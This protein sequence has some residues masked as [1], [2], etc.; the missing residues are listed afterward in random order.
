M[1][2]LKLSKR[3]VV[4]IVIVVIG[5]FISPQITVKSNVVQ[6]AGVDE[7]LLE[8]S[9]F[10]Q[11]MKYWDSEGIVFVTHDYPVNESSGNYFGLGNGTNNKIKQT[12]TI[13]ES[14][15]YS[16]SAL[17]RVSGSG[18]KFQ[19]IDTESQEVLVEDDIYEQNGYGKYILP[20]IY[21]ESTQRVT[22]VIAGSSNW[23][24]G[25]DV[26]LSYMDENNFLKNSGFSNRLN[27]WKVEGEAGTASNNPV[28]SNS[29]AH[30]WLANGD[31]NKLSQDVRISKDGYYTISAYLAAN[32]GNGKFQ[33]VD[34][35]S[36]MILTENIIESN[37]KY[38][39]YTLDLVYLKKYQHIS[40]VIV[41][42]NVWTNGDDVSL[43]YHDASNVLKN[44]GFW[45]K[46]A[47]WT[48][49]GLAGVASN[50]PVNDNSGTH[51]WLATGND[52]KVRQTVAITREGY[53]TASA[54]LTANASN[55]KFRILDV[56][57]GKILAD[58]EINADSKYKQY[59]L[60]KVYLTEGQKVVIEVLGS[61]GY[62]NGD[63]LSLVC[64]LKNYVSNG[65][66]EVYDSA[67]ESKCRD[68]VARD[69][70]MAKSY[71]TYL[72]N[73]YVNE[74]NV[75]MLEALGSERG[76]AKIEQE[77]QLEPNT[78]YELSGE[79]KTA[80]TNSS[81]KGAYITVSGSNSH[82][83]ILQDVQQVAGDTDWLTYK[84]DFLSPSDGKVKVIIGLGD[85]WNRVH[86]QAY[87]DNISITKC[88]NVIPLEGKHVGILIDNK[89]KTGQNLKPTIDYLD[90][91]YE[92]YAELVGQDPY[93]NNKLFFVP[94]Y[95]E[96]YAHAVALSG[97]PIKVRYEHTKN[98]FRPVSL[99]GNLALSFTLL[100]EM[101]HDFDINWS[102]SWAFRLELMANFKMFYVLEEY[103]KQYG[104]A[105]TGRDDKE[106]TM[107]ELRE[108]LE[109]GIRS[110][111]E[112]LSYIDD[113]DNMAVIPN[114]DGAIEYCLLRIKDKYGWGIFKSA[115]RNMKGNYYNNPLE[116]F[117]ALLEQLQ[118]SYNP[119][120]TEIKDTFQENELRYIR[121]YLQNASWG[122]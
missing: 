119:N 13:M 106:L 88:E 62:V 24:N 76:F 69:L 54:F 35:S 4:F 19:I 16:A 68:W 41:G 111:N 95:Q 22:I 66:M 20:P 101:G 58:C 107:E 92:K 48:V 15:I 104:Y 43:R 10:S 80:L 12:V 96:R 90:F 27:D 110:Y 49:E 85:Y 94:T 105:L 114:C 42:S 31:T 5:M 56:T 98:V 120:G 103:Q 37:G 28:N 17:L 8:N 117:N 44:A 46:M 3:V 116:S 100:H 2:R 21:L 25:D 78:R 39:K 64:E 32:S 87:F 9:D 67:V 34:S 79:I 77:I 59:N 81:S 18:G 50:N 75:M 65:D 26:C 6:A 40:V 73:N 47:D 51:F 84:I 115:F 63:N 36:G 108:E 112:M 30:F 99:N 70:Y 113:I 118:W 11:N 14:G 1:S 60:D 71:W 93:T 38:K 91:A 52:N 109:F 102:N 29:G 82:T 7:N 121:K 122:D 45:N 83:E 23:V 55:G 61:Y 74:T 72:E 53:Y 97:N 86:G 89:Y 57:T 33:L